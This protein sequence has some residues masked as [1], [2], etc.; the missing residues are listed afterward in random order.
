MSKKPNR[1]LPFF[2]WRHSSDN[3]LNV[4]PPSNT[5]LLFFLCASI[6]FYT[7]SA[8]QANIKF[9]H[10]GT[11]DGLSQS[12]AKCML[13]DSR[14]FIWVGTRDGLN[15]YDGYKFI[16]YKKDLKD[17]NSL[18]NDYIGDI[19]EDAKG[20]IWIGTMGGGLNKFDL[21]TNRFTHYK[22]KPNNPNGI[23]SNLITALA[24]DKYGN[25]WIGT[26]DAGLAMYTPSTNSFTHY[27][28]KK[29][30][31][32]LNDALINKI[33]ED[34]EGNVWVGTERA[35]LSLF[36]RKTKTFITFSNDI[37]D[38]ASISNN[39]IRTI[40]ED[41]R[42]N[43]WIGT[44][45]GGLNLLDRKTKKFS[46]FR[47]SDI[48]K[49]SLAN[50]HVLSL[51]ED[52]E[53]NI[54]V[55]SE[56]AGVTIFNYQKNTF[57][58]Y[59][60][61]ELDNT[62]LTN[63]SIHAMIR[64][65]KGNMWLGTFSG[66]ICYVDNDANKFTH[67]KHTSKNSLNH[68]KVLC[69]IEDSENNIWIG[70]DGGGLNM[71]NPKTGHFT[72]LTH[73]PGNPKSICGNYVLNIMEDSKGNLWIGTWGDGLTVYNRKKNSFKHFKH[74]AGNPTSLGI[75]HAW[76]LF[77]DRDKNIWIGTFGGGLSLYNP[78]TESFINYLH[79]DNNPR[80]ISDNKVQS[81]IENENG[82]LL[83]G[84][85]GG[86][87]NIF[88]KKLKTFSHFIH[89]DTKNSISNNNI[90]CL[91]KDQLN[92][93]W[94]GTM[95]G[96][97][98]IDTKQ[99]K[100]T[101]YT[102]TNGLPNNV[103][104]GILE[105]KKGNLWIST[106]NGL[107][108]FNI[109]DK[110]FKNFNVSDGLQSNEFKEKASCKTRSGE[111]YFGG[112]NGFN[113][114]FPESIKNNIY[115][116]PLVL[117]DFQ[118]F[119]SPVQ[120][121]R[122]EK[123]PSPLK[124]SITET[125]ELTLPYKYSV[126]AFEFASLNYTISDKKQYAYKLEG[127]DKEWNN[128]GTKHSAT[129]TNLQPG[130]Y[131]FK[132][133]GLNNEGRWSSK[134]VSL[135]LTITPPFWMTWWFKSFVAIFIAGAVISFFLFRFNTVKAQKLK[136]EH[137]VK[138]RTEQLVVLTQQER[139]AREDAEAANRAKST[140]LA[141]MSHEI[142]TPMNGVIG[143]TSLLIETKLDNEQE[144][145]VDIIRSSGENLLSVIND[146]LDFSKIESGKMEL[147]HEPFDLRN[148]IEEVLD[149]FA[150]KAA[151]NGLDLV[152][153]LEHDVN[154]QIFGD[155]IRLK[156]VLM[157]LIGNAIKFTKQ[158]EIFVGVK[159][160]NQKAKDI[161]IEFEVRDTGIG[162]PKDK[163]NTLFEAFT[164]V[165]SSTTRKYGGTG[166]GLAICKKLV[167]LMQGKIWIK[168][169]DGKG[170]SFFFTIKTQPSTKSIRSFIYANT[171]ELAGK[172]ILVVDDNPTNRK[173][174]KK[175]LELWKFIPVLAESGEE[176]LGLLSQEKFDMVISDMQ[177]PG[178][179]GAQLGKRI[180]DAQPDMPIILLSSIGDE[181]NKKYRDLFNH[182]LAKPT[183]HHELNNVIINLFKK[184]TYKAYKEDPRQIL[185][186]DFAKKYPLSILI[187]EDNP[188]NQ[189]LIMMVM[190]KLGYA[191]DLAPNG[192][193]ALEA[194]VTKPYNIILMDVQMPDMDGLEAT[195]IIR[196]QSAHQPVIIAVTANAMQDDK[197]VCTEA[198]MDD[199][200]SKPIQLEKLM[201]VLEKWASKKIE[202]TT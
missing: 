19:V 50:D 6:V 196:Q 147:E 146:I 43:L 3:D 65:A 188:V 170:T 24:K 108:H 38:P 73:K 195:R 2:S 122:D 64:T 87:L 117:T 11:A 7:S 105:D 17:S 78:E 111:M 42:K 97:N 134:T 200:I 149:L 175:Q 13:Q 142:R 119:N 102:M 193:K 68:N 179:D 167:E 150:G 194:L 32:S 181:R 163:I 183:K 28:P 177:M 4:S 161:E 14:G 176:A 101:V 169:E 89:S 157:N 39:S 48:N 184:T 94:I 133:K 95:A 187:A 60:G 1:C 34:S 129:Y 36:D 16:V 15:K 140:F 198:G 86:G 121:A 30:G 62:S 49:N 76:A 136:L 164:Q 125:K 71:Y 189:T 56:N 83:I 100:I 79:D 20:N 144:K 110:S 75:N 115:E 124:K 174:L 159:I 173:I 158:G 148:N 72:Y 82:D 192:V 132:V 47:H 116:P 153:E 67:L 80:S 33:Y 93:L 96:L 190:K 120:V 90:N 54:W 185:S 103:I 141:T 130:S 145:Y 26:E 154:Q 29:D 127:F 74:V 66:G 165:D 202:I 27:P 107:S 138:E 53:G 109:K 191:A 41:S 135:Q 197:D 37:K 139:K 44:L 199:Y 57:H 81:I 31:K 126:I 8:Q 40:F 113:K 118:I 59:I 22:Y 45:G 70:T 55:G 166:L 156:Q 160:I 63:N 99:N 106:N 151:E 88:N 178:M 9:T 92:N 168:S 23:P 10:I 143:T 201:L 98:F 5:K 114:F 25:L 112:N 84:T 186:A 162:I 61:D 172:R 35:G 69:I 152:Y 12:N 180:K 46:S 137:L 123:D 21:Q 58:V 104:F 18:S 171:G 182:V 155:R 85:H 91:Y 77:E 51:G 131:T 128:V 52:V